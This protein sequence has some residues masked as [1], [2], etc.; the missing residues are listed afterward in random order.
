MSS[1]SSIEELI[2]LFSRI[3][4]IGPKSA[5]RITYFLLQS[6]KEYVNSLADAIKVIKQKIK[7]CRICG[8][9]TETDICDICADHK[10]DKHKI[11]VV[12]EPKDLMVIERLKIYNGLYHIL[13]GVISPIHGVGPDDLNIRPFIQRVKSSEDNIDEIIVA[14]NPTSEGDTTAFYISK[15]LKDQKIRI[16][17]IAYGIPVGAN[18]DYTDIVTLTRSFLDRKV[19]E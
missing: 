1:Y 5:E 18:I 19:F 6:N 15:L 8:N 11:C 10:R 4:G 13:F 14:T 17:R 3:P 2:R 16:T 7:N 12:E 9:Y